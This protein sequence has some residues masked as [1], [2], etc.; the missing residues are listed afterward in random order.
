MYLYYTDADKRHPLVSLR[1]KH[2]AVNVKSACE[3]DHLLLTHAAGVWV[4]LRANT[5][6]SWFGRPSCRQA[7]RA[8][9]GPIRSGPVRYRK[10][11]LPAVV[12][13]CQAESYAKRGISR[14]TSETHEER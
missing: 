13:V 14:E 7:S 5:Y 8:K 11:L 4:R 10:L 1:E 2:S 12:T 9:R 3:I 6:T